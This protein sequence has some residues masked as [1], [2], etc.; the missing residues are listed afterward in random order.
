MASQWW[1]I[2][3]AD[4]AF[5]A[6][7]WRDSYREA[8]TEA[9]L[10]HGAT[11]WDWVEVPW[12]V[13]LEVAFP[14]EADWARFRTLPGVR[15]ALDAVPDPV[16]GLYLY[17]GRG[18]SSGAGSRRRPRLPVGAGAAPLPETEEPMLVARSELAEP[19]SG[20]R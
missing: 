17:P 20:L 1:S 8:L 4:G 14:E 3:V 13:V 19:A 7:M 16:H 15:A 5:S 10:T 9:A 12:G 11:E 2:E 6:A 18:G